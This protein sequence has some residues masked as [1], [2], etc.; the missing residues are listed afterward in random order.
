MMVND[1]VRP[2]WSPYPERAR[3]AKARW[4]LWSVSQNRLRKRSHRFEERG[5]HSHGI[6]NLSISLDGFATGEPQSAEAPFGHAGERLPEWM[7]GTRFLDAGGTVG[8]DD[9]FAA[10][11]SYGIGAEIIGA[12]KFGPPGWQKDPSWTGWWGASPPFRTDLRAHPPPAAP[13]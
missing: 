3:I 12:N 8:V 5:C 10:R 13:D 11:H 1:P 6:H 7:F 4:S 2:W 9:A